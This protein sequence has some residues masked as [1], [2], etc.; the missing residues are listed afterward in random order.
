MFTKK[1]AVL[2]TIAMNSRSSSARKTILLTGGSGV[3]G[4]ALLA[5]LQA[6]C[7]ICL[8]RATPVNVPGVTTVFGDISHPRLGISQVQW[9]DIAKRIDCIVHAAAVTDFSQSDHLIKRVNLDGLENMLELAAIAQVPI[10]TISTAFINACQCPEGRESMY[11]ISKRQGEQLVRQSGLK[12][13]IVRPSI[14]IGD[15]ETGQI[16]RFQGIYNVVGGWLRGFLPLVPM[17]PQAYIDFV[18]QDTVANAIATLV[19]HDCTGEFWLTSGSQALTVRQIAEI[20]VEFAHNRGLMVDFPQ[21]VDPAFLEKLNHPGVVSAL[22]KSARKGF[23]W[24]KQV[25]PYLSNNVP[26][27]SSLP[28]LNA[29]CRLSPPQLE[30]AFMQSLEYWADTARRKSSRYAPVKN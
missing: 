5:R 29:H 1:T 28:A 16:A 21:F 19:E 13:T 25:S 4:Q 20:V 15:S 30:T 10:H 6:H 8:T 23:S 14:V 17:L 9:E 27:P 11:T 24:F 22:P 7:V 3:V 12:Y 2:K 18:P 26:F